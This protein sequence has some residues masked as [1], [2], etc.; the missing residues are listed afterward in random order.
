MRQDGHPLHP[1]HGAH[2]D[3]ERPQSCRTR[4]ISKTIN[5]PNE[6][7]VD[8]VIDAYMQSW[9]HG[10]KAMA[11]YRDG[12]KLSQP[13]SSKSDSR[14]EDEG[15]VEELFSTAVAEALSIAQAE[16]ERDREAVIAD[17][18]AQAKLEWER[19]QAAKAPAA[20]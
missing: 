18:V 11:L 9:E 7:T 17:A 14:A 5:M 4:G 19:E 2:P 12:S 1:P 10:I 3:D 20:V 13:L 15:E 8:D 16:W 6:A